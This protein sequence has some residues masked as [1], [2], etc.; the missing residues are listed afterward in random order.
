[1]SEEYDPCECGAVDW[2]T[3]P[4][5]INCNHCCRLWGRVNEVWVFDPES[6][7]KEVHESTQNK[8]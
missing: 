2:N 4:T 3:K 7:P 1:M 6:A 8:F 5:L